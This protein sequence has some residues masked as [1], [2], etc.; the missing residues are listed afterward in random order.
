MEKETCV[1]LFWSLRKN[2]KKNFGDEKGKRRSFFGGNNFKKV[3][4]TI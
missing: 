3:F 2:E 4:Q 1:E